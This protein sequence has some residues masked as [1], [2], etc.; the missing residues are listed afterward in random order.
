MGLFENPSTG[1]RNSLRHFAIPDDSLEFAGNV[2][3]SHTVCAPY[4]H[5]M[6]TVQ[7]VGDLTITVP[8]KLTGVDCIYGN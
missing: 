2:H 3:G 5:R 1:V 4:L 6:G 8:R 7:N